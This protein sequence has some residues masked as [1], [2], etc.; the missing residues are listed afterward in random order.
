[1]ENRRAG[2]I[3][4]ILSWPQATNNLSNISL[5]LSAKTRNSHTSVI[6][7]L[8][9][10]RHWSLKF[11]WCKNLLP[12]KYTALFLC[13]S[14][15]VR[16]CVRGCVCA[17][18][19]HTPCSESFYRNSSQQCNLWRGCRTAFYSSSL[20]MQS[21]FSPTITAWPVWMYSFQRKGWTVKGSYPCF[22]MVLHMFY[23]LSILY[24]CLSFFLTV[25]FSLFSLHFPCIEPPCL[26]FNFSTV[27][28]VLYRYI[29]VI[30]QQ[31]SH[32]VELTERWNLSR[33]TVLHP[34]SVVSENTPGRQEANISVIKPV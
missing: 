16:A 2:T 33:E 24:H 6:G 34:W 18:A 8:Q 32:W 20:L 25:C 15:F 7:W 9:L 1:M 11:F 19:T 27:S 13:R 22:C 30:I 3:E 23:R 21:H 12:Y 17:C 10:T 5:C 14:L 4:D 26:C 28:S 29:F 31:L